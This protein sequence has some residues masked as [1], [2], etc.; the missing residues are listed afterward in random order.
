MIHEKI[1]REAA[2]LAQQ[3]LNPDMVDSFLALPLRDQLTGIAILAAVAGDVEV[4]AWALDKLQETE[5][6]APLV[7]LC[8]SGVTETFKAVEDA[9]EKAQQLVAQ[10]TGSDIW[11]DGKLTETRYSNGR[12]FS[13]SAE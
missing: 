3:V 10:R 2:E 8:Y 12:F 4:R 9:R 11:V 1:N 13:Y 5:E 6:T 7:E